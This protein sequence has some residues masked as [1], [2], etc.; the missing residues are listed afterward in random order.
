MKTFNVTFTLVVGAQTDEH[1]QTPEAL[2]SE[3]TSW[4]EYLGSTVQ[5]LVVR[6]VEEEVKS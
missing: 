2:A 6:S 3:I 1:L 4:F 5:L